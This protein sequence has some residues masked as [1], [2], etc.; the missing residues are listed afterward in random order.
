M[1]ITFAE[2]FESPSNEERFR[3]IVESNVARENPRLTIDRILASGQ[4]VGR[5][6]EF[7][8]AVRQLVRTDMDAARAY[9]ESYSNQQYRYYFGSI[10]AQQMVR[11]D[12]ASALEW[13]R[14][15]DSPNRPQIEISVLSTIAASDPQMAIDEALSIDRADRRTMVLTNVI[16]EIGTDDPQAAIG[17]VDQIPD[18]QQRRMALMQVS[19]NWLTREPEAAIDWVLTQE[20]EL[21]NEVIASAGYQLMHT[22]V[23]MAIRLL[24]R[25][26]EES[27]QGWR[28]QIAQQLAANRSVGE[29]QSFV[30]QFENQPG[31]ERLQASLIE[32]VALQDPLMAKQLADQLTDLTARDSAYMQIIAR[33]TQTNPTEAINW[34]A[35]ITDDSMR[36][37]A[38]G[39]LASQWYTTDPQAATIWVTNLP[40]GPS[41]DDAIVQ[42]S[43]QWTEATDTQLDLIASISDRDKRG[44][45]KIRRIYHVMQTDPARA[46]ELLQDEDIPDYLRQQTQVNL[47]RNGWRY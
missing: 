6:N 29:A 16:T 19:Q 17:Y 37:A 39:Q 2:L 11:D 20:G 12:P 10:I 15:N 5:S 35:N 21:A 47:S 18:P 25:L 14:E 36:G 45:A 1:A 31:Y 27:Q 44:Q 30:A 32:G 46:R 43:Y 33:R 28:L 40:A 26:D 8:S 24:P 41:R 13:A 7:F 23:D 9:F 4:D 34:L 22:N 38:T 3:S 42:M